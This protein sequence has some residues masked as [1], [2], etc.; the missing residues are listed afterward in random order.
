[1]LLLSS[2]NLGVV[3]L[4]KEVQIENKSEISVILRCMSSKIITF[5]TYM[6]DS[7]FMSKTLYNE[8]TRVDFSVY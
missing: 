2:I 3:I 8:M 1:M 6:I 7:H 5:L 4:T